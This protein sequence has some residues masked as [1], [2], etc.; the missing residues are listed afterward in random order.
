M[1]SGDGINEGFYRVI[2][3]DGHEIL[4]QTPPG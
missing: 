4:F 1:N 2:F 3:D